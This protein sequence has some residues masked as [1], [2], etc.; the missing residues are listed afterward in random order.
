MLP[1]KNRL[2]DDY[3]FRR[4]KRIGKSFVTNLFIISY[5]PS[6]NKDL[7]S[8]FGFIFSAS[9]E[10]RATV[11]NRHKRLLREAIRT[12]L[13]KFKLG[14]DIVIIPRKSLIGKTYEEIGNIFDWALPKIPLV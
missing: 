6:K 7:E 4:V 13:G 10:K 14:Y 3:D 2:L 8:R 12:R 11:R 1:F 9:F 5:A